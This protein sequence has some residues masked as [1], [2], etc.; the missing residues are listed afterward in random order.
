M[1]LKYPL[2]VPCMIHSCT[3]DIP[4]HVPYMF[5]S[6]PLHISYMSLRSPLH[7]PFMSLTC[8]LHVPY[9]SLSC[10]LHV[11]YMSPSYLTCPLG[12]LQTLLHLKLLG[13]G[14]VRVLEGPS[15]LK[16]HYTA[17]LHCTGNCIVDQEMQLN[18]TSLVE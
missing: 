15:P 4:L 14:H 10:P 11:P 2:Q 12:T 5:L 17:G 3:L 8:P 1:S 18:R 7:V 6:Y 16:R 9:K 13:Y